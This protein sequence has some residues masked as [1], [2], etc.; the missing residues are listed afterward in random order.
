MET[1]VNLF[2]HTDISPTPIDLPLNVTPLMALQLATRYSEAELATSGLVGLLKETRE[3][4]HRRV[5]LAL[6][7][8]SE[9]GVT[10]HELV[11]LVDASIRRIAGDKL[12]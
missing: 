4:L 6:N 9:Y 11:A 1:K 10:R 2:I 8:L 7:E 5:Q 3:V 12:K